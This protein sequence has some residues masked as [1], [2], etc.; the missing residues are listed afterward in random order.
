MFQDFYG[1]ILTTLNA[2]MDNKYQPLID[3]FQ[4]LAIT[5]LTIY[6]MWTAY[7]IMFGNSKKPLE[8]TMTVAV[9]IVITFI[10]F[11]YATYKEYIMDTILYLS[12]RLQGYFLTIDGSGLPSQTFTNLENTFTILFSKLEELEDGMGLWSVTGIQ[13]M[14]CVY[15]LKIIFSILYLVFAILVIFST[16]AIFVFFVIGG[17]PLFL[18][19]VPST[20]FVFW[21]WLRAVLNYTLIPI[22]TSIVMAISLK[23]LGAVV[24]DLVAMDIEKNGIFNMAVANAYF[25][26]CLAIFFH[27]K[28]PEFAAALTG[29]QPSGIGGFFA[30]AIGAGATAFGVAKVGKAVGMPLGKAGVTAGVRGVNAYLDATG[31]ASKNFSA[32]RGIQR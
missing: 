2:F 12:F 1:Q 23:F 29:G 8:L 18:A 14:L 6:I 10:V 11:S 22:F 13:L 28:A 27:L 3:S 24:D 15:G 31:E 26:G 30:G 20:R 4:P 25:I 5:I 16:F 32:M 9:S 7:S 21:S 19:I 17:I